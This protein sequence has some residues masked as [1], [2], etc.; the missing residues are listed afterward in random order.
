MAEK[1]AKGTNPANY[2]VTPATRVD[3]EPSALE[4]NNRGDLMIE[5]AGNEM[6]TKVT[7]SGSDTYEATAPAGTAQASA[8]WRAKKV[9]VSGGTTIVTWADGNANYDNVATDLTALSYS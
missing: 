4:V 1:F 6:A 2:N 8:L 9:T 7:I 5:E 3:G